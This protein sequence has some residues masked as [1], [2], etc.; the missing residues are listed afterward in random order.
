M[1]TLTQP[2]FADMPLHASL[3][4]ALTEMNFTEPSPIQAAAIPVLIDGDDVIG[5]AQTGT[6]KTAAFALPVLQ[7]VRPHQRNV[8]ALILCP[9]RELALQVTEAIKKMGKYVPKLL[10]LAVYGG[11]PINKQLQ[12]LRRHPQ[13]IVGTPG[14]VLD[15]LRRG[16]LDLSLV[17]IS[18]LDEADE[19]LN[20]GF[21][22][23]IETILSHTPK[24]R[25]TVMFSATM[26]AAIRALTQRH[27]RNPK[28]IQVSPSDEAAPQIDQHYIELNRVPKEEAL[29]RLMDQQQF[30]LSLVF[31]NTKWQVDSLVKRL[32]NEG[33]AVDGLHG[34][35]PQAKR[36]KIMQRFR[37]GATTTLIATDVAA[38]GID[39]PQID[40]VVN[41]DLPREM[42]FYIHRIGR[43]GRAGS[44][45]RAFT[46]IQNNELSQLRRLRNAH[47]V[48]L[49]RH[50]L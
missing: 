23:D 39:V 6:G 9:T 40:A 43:T 34:G 31:C 21:S 4:K 35:M 49:T 33:Y 47:N 24:T 20:M 5:L 48:T 17:D 36:D 28:T 16:D 50:P 18:V 29:I 3:H 25:Q 7:R 22:Q 12:V 37:K 13:V 38:R 14:R 42:A 2:A 8:Q 19:M 26:P 32:R 41:I 1:P 30:K 10:V 44:T 27:L 15:L 11:Q 46:F 45:G